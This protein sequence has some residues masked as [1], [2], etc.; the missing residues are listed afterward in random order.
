MCTVRTRQRTDDG[1]HIAMAN[2]MASE[3]AHGAAEEC[4]ADAFCAIV[5]M[6]FFFLRSAAVS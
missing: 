2:F 6:M 1:T 5:V 3:G 4:G